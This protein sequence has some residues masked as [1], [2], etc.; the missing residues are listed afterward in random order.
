MKSLYVT[1]ALVVCVL[2]SY[3]SSSSA[4]RAE[5]YYDTRLVRSWIELEPS[6]LEGD[7]FLGKTIYRSG[8]RIA[9]G[10]AHAFSPKELL[11]PDRLRR[12][13]SI[14]RL[15]FS[16]PKYVTRDEDR[17][18]AVT[19]LLLYFLEQREQDE[20]LKSLITD[21]EKYISTQAGGGSLN[22]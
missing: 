18:P 15:S 6:V 8:D 19:R 9:L 17:D 12:I 10:I 5:D 21:T 2:A 13:L 4:G 14:V 3:A 16:R 7:A 22:H 11:D 1:G 20:K